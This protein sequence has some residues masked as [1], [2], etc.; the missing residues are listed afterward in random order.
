[1]EKRAPRLQFTDEERT[2]SALKKPIRK[3]DRA[4]EKADRAQAKVTKKT[5]L[6]RQGY[7]AP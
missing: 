4:M 5:A 7:N 1:M 3:V 6:K 2:D